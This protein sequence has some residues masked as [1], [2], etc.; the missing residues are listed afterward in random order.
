MNLKFL[1]ELK[2]LNLPEDKFAIFGSGPIAIRNLR[3]NRDLDVIV[4][5]DLWKKLMKIYPVDKSV[6]GIKIGCI[7][8]WDSWPGFENID[9][10]IDN[11]DIIEWIR[12]VK[13]ENV[14]KWKKVRNMQKDKE[15]IK[16][17]EDYLREEE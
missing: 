14:L 10:L 6:N 17:I 9:E 7:E 12:F 2:K 13:L 15:D 3:M 8:I 4:K 16:L 11:A 1:S 5:K